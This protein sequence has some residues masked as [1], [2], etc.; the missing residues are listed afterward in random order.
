MAID[1]SKECQKSLADVNEKY[2]NK[3]SQEATLSYGIEK[4]KVLLEE[5]FDYQNFALRKQLENTLTFEWSG[6]QT[7]VDYYQLLKN[8]PLSEL[9]LK[10]QQFLEKEKHA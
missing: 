4:S 8:T 2:R 6:C 1:Y 9:V 10:I 5:L 3:W 7:L